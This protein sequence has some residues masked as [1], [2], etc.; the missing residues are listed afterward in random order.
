MHISQNQELSLNRWGEI[1]I[2]IANSFFPLYILILRVKIVYIWK[3]IMMEGKIKWVARSAA[4]FYFCSF[5]W[6]IS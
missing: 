5:A 3:I 6:K 4:W 1:L 2:E